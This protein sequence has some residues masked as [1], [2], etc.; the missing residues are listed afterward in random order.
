MIRNP[1]IILALCFTIIIFSVGNCGA[2]PPGPFPDAVFNKNIKTVLLYKQGWEFS[3]PVLQLNEPASLVFSFDEL[4]A[5]QKNYNYSV[6]LCDADWM[7]SRLS[8]SEYMDGFFQNPLITYASSFSTHIPYIHYSLQIPNDNVKLKLSGNY[9]LFVYENGNE[10]EPVLI[11]RFM[12]A[13]EKITI[14]GEVK[15]PVLAAYQDEFQQVNF[16]IQHPD[17]PIENPCQTVK[18]T[19]LKNGIWKFSGDDIKPVYIREA[20]ILYDSP[21]KNLFP[22][23]NEYRSFDLKSMKYQSANIESMG[24]DNGMYHMA[25][26]PEGP[27][28]RAGYFYNE[29]ING[30]CLIQN[31]QGRTPETDAEYVHVLF[32]FKKPTVLENGDMYVFGSFSDFNCNDDNKMTYNQEKG[33]YQLDLLVKQGYY[34]YQYVFVPKGTSDTDE[35]YFEGSFYETEND[36]MILVYHRPYGARYDRLVGVKVFNSV[37]RNQ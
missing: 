2:L 10:D 30:K 6:V 13:D 28:N 12:V 5:T 34:N 33:M 36:Y 22:G 31:Q 9:A 11:K 25:L 29:D 17:Y 14:E 8:Y 20:E 26:K 16:S 3:Y 32:S 27:R 35:K 15:R 24:F 19:V 7:P 4:N 18:V 21:D 23:G 1:G 37:K